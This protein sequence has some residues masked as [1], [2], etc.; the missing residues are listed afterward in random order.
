MSVFG[1]GQIRREVPNLLG[2]DF[3]AARALELQAQVHIADPDP[4]APPI[5]NYWWEHQHLVVAHQD[6]SAGAWIERYGSVRVTLAPPDRFDPARATPLTPLPAI[7]ARA[8][9]DLD[10]RTG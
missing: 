9:R 7:Y 4:D 1:D 5:S 3:E 10:G 8:E 2:L 6:P